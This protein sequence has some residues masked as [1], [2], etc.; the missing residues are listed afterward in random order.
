MDANTTDSEAVLPLPEVTS[1]ALVEHQERQ[2]AERA[3]LA[4][5]WEDDGLVFPAERGT[6]VKPA[7][8]HLGYKLCAPPPHA[9][10][11][12]RTLGSLVHASP[13]Q[14]AAGPLA[15]LSI[16]VPPAPRPTPARDAASSCCLLQLA[17]ADPSSLV[18]NPG[19]GRLNRP[20]ARLPAASIVPVNPWGPGCVA[21]DQ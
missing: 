8:R 14:R 20:P 18:A 6:P 12:G 13:R 10:R 21:S 17:T 1:L 19:T 16:A 9:S 2:Q 15:L 5:V 4:E 3:A 7:R 11:N